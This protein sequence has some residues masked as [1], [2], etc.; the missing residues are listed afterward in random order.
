[1]ENNQIKTILI[2]SLGRREYGSQGRTLEW[3]LFRCYCGNEFEVRMESVLKGHT[4]S[5]GCLHKNKVKESCTTH[6]LSSHHLSGRWRGM[7]GR[8]YNKNNP[9]YSI[10]GG[11][12]ITVCDE[13]DN[14]LEHTTNF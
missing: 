2:K 1:M 7:K 10:Y 4:K 9:K 11:R 6:G 14:N 8:C 12:G 5:C 13:K 3:G